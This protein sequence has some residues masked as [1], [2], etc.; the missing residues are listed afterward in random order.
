MHTHTDRESLSTVRNYLDQCF[1]LVFIPP[2]RYQQ[3]YNHVLQTAYLLSGLPRPVL[4][5]TLS[6]Y[7]PQMNKITI[8]T[9]KNRIANIIISLTC[10]KYTVV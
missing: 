3:N 8:C 1:W 6:V 9:L 7:K 5:Q 10:S 4:Q 2:E